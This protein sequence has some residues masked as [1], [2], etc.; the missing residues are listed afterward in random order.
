VDGGGTLNSYRRAY[1]QG[2]DG[3]TGEL[4]TAVLSVSVG[5]S[6]TVTVGKGGA[7]GVT[8]KGSSNNLT[9]TG[10]SNGG[11]SSCGSVVGRRWWWWYWGKNK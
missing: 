2:G 8:A 9:G 11:N 7:N 4:K 3:G 6:F 1:S 5:S 10:G